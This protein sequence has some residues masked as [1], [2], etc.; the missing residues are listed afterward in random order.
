MV[1][2]YSIHLPDGL[3]EYIKDIGKERQIDYELVMHA[4][5]ESLCHIAKSQYG[6]GN[7]KVH[8]QH[9]QI[10]C[11][12]YRNIVEN[13]TDHN[14]EISLSA[15]DKIHTKHI[16][17]N[18]CAELLPGLDL[19]RKHMK[20]FKE[21]F[22]NKILNFEKQRIYKFYKDRVGDL[23]TGI[24]KHIDVQYRN[25]VGNIEKI[26]YGGIIIDIGCEAYLSMHET[27]VGFD[28]FQIGD[29]VKS[30][31]TN[32]EYTEN[33]RHVVF[34]SRRNSEFIK[35]L[36][37]SSIPEITDGIV[38]IKKI[39]RLPGIRSKVAVYSESIDPVGI[40]IGAKGTKIKSIS[41]E[42]Q[43]EQIDI[44]QWSHDIRT[45]IFNCFKN[46]TLHHILFE[47]EQNSCILVV[48]EESKSSVIGRNGQN[49]KLVSILLDNCEI[50]LLSLDEYNQSLQTND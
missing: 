15:V 26:A 50:T 17:D 41:S 27:I 46:V 44:V 33:D 22:L 47:Q 45:F 32:V 18:V 39:A 49:I 25:V 3:S 30:I 13:V 40:C 48:S 24:V 5:K 14:T 37:V 10:F 11:W 28:K 20:L 9:N 23:V 8:V 6:N 42:A 34:L 19:N 31:I 43:Y 36:M 7:I 29:R 4:F 12:L 1:R 2:G 21:Y 35:A 38:E 16:Q